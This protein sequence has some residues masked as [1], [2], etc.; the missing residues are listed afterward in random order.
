VPDLS[1]RAFLALAATAV[2]AACSDDDAGAPPSTTAPPAGPTTAATASSTSTSA[3][4]TTTTPPSTSAALPGDPFALGVTAGDPDATSVV[5]WTR[6]VGDGLPDAVDVMWETSTDE[7]ATVASS[8]TATATAADGHSV[9][10]VVDISG[11][12]T[13]RFQAGGFTS[14]AGRAA[15]AVAGATGLRIAAATCQHFETGLYAAHRDLTEWAPDVVV[16]LGDFIYEGGGRPVGGQVLRSH[17]GPEPRDVAGYRGRYAQ[18]LGDPQLQAARAACPWWVI[19]DDHEVENNYAG[20]VPQDPADAGGFADRRL[21]AYQVW[22]EHMPVRIPKPQPAVD[23]VI[24]RT[25]HYGDLLDLVLLDGRQFRSDQACGDAT[26]S[27]EPPCAEAADP[28]R[29]MLGATQEAWT[30]AAFAASTATWAVLGQQTVLADLRLS[31]GAIL[32]EDQWDGYAPARDRLLA[33]AAPAAGR[34]VVLTGDIHLAGVGRLPD[35]GTEFVTTSV[36]STGNVPAN[37]QPIIAGFPSIVDAELLH[38]GYI[39][40]TVT[41]DTWTAEYR[42]VDDIT[43]AD[44]GVSTWRTF[45]VPAGASTAVTAA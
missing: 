40:H 36:S 10:A 34:L 43:R 37:L 25:G 15:P 24:Y 19:W 21:A 28:S 4:S 38:R 14:P 29:T 1:R 12:V 45:S 11:P 17:D 13:Y 5:L 33:A 6:L 20:L 32:N 16:F 9:H 35:V 22:W 8:G 23:T 41:P 30:T 7:F 42:T 39:R 27:T 18:Y 2:V 44:S 26:L 3:S 31:N